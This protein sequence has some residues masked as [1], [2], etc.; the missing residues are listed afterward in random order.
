MVLVYI[1]QADQQIKK[2]SLEALSYGAALAK[3]LGCS[4]EALVFGTVKDQLADLGKFGTQKVHQL[5]N[6]T[7]NSLDKTFSASIKTLTAVWGSER[8]LERW[9]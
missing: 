8:S 3:Q 6:E 9:A 1:D 7:L 2:A 5:K 4:T